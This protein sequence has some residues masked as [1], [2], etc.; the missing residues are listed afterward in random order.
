MRRTLT[1]EGTKVIHTQ[2]TSGKVLLNQAEQTRGGRHERTRLDTALALPPPLFLGGGVADRFDMFHK[3][4]LFLTI[5]SFEFSSFIGPVLQSA[6]A[7]NVCVCSMP[8][9]DC[10]FS[11]LLMQIW[12]LVL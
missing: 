6:K 12:L 7:E 4:I 5:I 2:G 3:C 1:S 11:L 10:R 8:E 9:P